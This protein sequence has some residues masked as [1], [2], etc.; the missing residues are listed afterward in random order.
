MQNEMKD[1]ENAPHEGKR[2]VVLFSINFIKISINFPNSEL[3]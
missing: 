1:V 3:K 2:R